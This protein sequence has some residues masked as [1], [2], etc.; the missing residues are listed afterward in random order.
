[1]DVGPESDVDAR[2]DAPINDDGTYNARV[3]L[4]EGDNR[5]VA[6]CTT[7]DGDVVASTP[8]TYVV[9]IADRPTARAT[10]RIEGSEVVLDA[11]ASTPSEASD[12][13]LASFAWSDGG[14]G[15]E[16]RIPAPTN[17]GAHT[18]T[19][20]VT[21]ANG[22]TD[23]AAA[24][25]VVED[26]AGA[27]RVPPIDEAPAWIAGAVVYGAV[28]PLFGYGGLSSLTER[29]DEL[30]DLGVDIVWLSPI[31]EATFG[32]FGFDVTNHFAINP[33]LG[34][35]DDLRALVSAA[36]ERGL[37]VIL[38][39]VP[40]HTSNQHP[41]YVDAQ[42]HGED[43][44]YWA[45]H[46]RDD[47]GDA[48]FYFD[49]EYLL[50]LDYD[51]AEVARMMTEALSR[52]VRD[53]DVDGFRVDAAWGVLDRSP[54]YWDGLRAELHRIKPD[55]FLL[56]EAG[57]RDARMFPVFDAGYDWTD[58]LGVWAWQ[59]AFDAGPP[60][61][62]AL[63]DAL[64]AVLERNTLHFLDNNDTGIRFREEYGDDVTRPARALSMFAPGLAG[65]YVGDEI[66]ARFDP[67]EQY[68]PLEWDAAD[69]ALRDEIRAMTAARHA[70]AAFQ[71]SAAAFVGTDAADD[72]VAFTRGAGDDQVLV[73]I[74]FAAV[75]RNV[76]VDGRADPIALPA[77]DW[78]IVE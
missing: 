67:Y 23:R 72:V 36:H 38:D 58:D 71:T 17:E 65:L 44:R 46:D 61:G 31:N 59:S 53:F 11:S 5:I 75:E 74:S 37:R 1:V 22:K 57:A 51:D 45:F 16:V 12:A 42:E 50:N 15:A 29:L 30:V 47:N 39:V 62:P 3:A 56:G 4:D 33:E 35:E 7:L 78:R 34:N 9:R 24:V 26:G 25:V 66:G 28:P 43:S 77:Y 48:S 60:Y 6:R 69:P 21:D 13:A 41:Y 10:A 55:V 20:D 52:W 8:R 68:D 32:D 14:A 19:V 63:R 76:T 70:H 18:F 27:V 64:A 54:G 49:W 2:V 73:L 40:N